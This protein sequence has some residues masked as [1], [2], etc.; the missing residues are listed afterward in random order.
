MVYVSGTLHPAE[1]RSFVPTLQHVSLLNIMNQRYLSYG[2]L[3]DFCRFIPETVKSFMFD[4]RCTGNS[5]LIENVMALYGDLYMRRRQCQPC[6]E[7]ILLIVTDFCQPKALEVQIR[8]LVDMLIDVPAAY[9]SIITTLPADDAILDSLLRHNFKR[10]RP[11]HFFNINRCF[12]KYD[13]WRTTVDGKT[14]TIGFLDPT[15][16]PLPEAHGALI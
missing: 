3:V 4:S 6:F 7:K 2:A 1:L 14:V 9:A 16:P 11:G 12:E 13:Y 10:A 5:T 15:A 8:R